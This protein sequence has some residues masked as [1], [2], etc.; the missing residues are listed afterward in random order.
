MS[1][2]GAYD[3]ERFGKVNR[4]PVRTTI[5]T[6]FYGNN[7]KRVR[8]LQKA[9]ALAKDSPR[10]VELTGMPVFRPEDLELPADANVL[11]FKDR[12]SHV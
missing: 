2:I 10:T 3:A 8:D 9:Y 11:L 5:E 7:V 12:K 4:T 6:L 1:T